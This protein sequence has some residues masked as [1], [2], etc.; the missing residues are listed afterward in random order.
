MLKENNRLITQEKELATVMN[1]FFANITKS[2]DLKKNDDLSLNLIDPKNINDILEKHNYHPSV[3]EISQTFMTNEKFSFQFMTEDQVREEIMNLDSSHATP[4][5][6]ISVDTLKSTVDIH[7]PFITNR[8]NLSIEKG[9]FPEEL[10]IAEFSPIL[11]KRDGLDKEN[12]K[13]VSVLPR[14]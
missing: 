8:I 2:L 13:P 10:K 1:T 14:V 12:Y 7:L 6:D 3:H 4:I 5:G 11:K 9:C